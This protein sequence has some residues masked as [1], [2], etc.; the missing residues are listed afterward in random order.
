M[1][2]GLDKRG[3]AGDDGGRRS[4][5]NERMLIDPLMGTVLVSAALLDTGLVVLP[6]RRNLHRQDARRWE[7]ERS[8]KFIRLRNSR[9]ASCR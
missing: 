5:S 3:S 9:R 4:T 6:R 8:N 1:P 2:P 7:A